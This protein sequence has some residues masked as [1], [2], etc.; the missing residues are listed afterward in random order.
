MTFFCTLSI[1]ALGLT[2]G[3]WQGRPATGEMAWLTACIASIACAVCARP[4]PAECA[5]AQ[6]VLPVVL[7][8]V[9]GVFAGSQLFAADSMLR[10]H[11][12]VWLLLGC[13]VL[14]YTVRRGIPSLRQCRTRIV[15]IVMLGFLL[16]SI[17]TIRDD[18]KPRIDVFLMQQASAKAM[19]E[20]RNPYTVSIPD[21][22]GPGSPYY[23]PLTRNGRTLYGFNY[24]PAMGFLDVPAY[25]LT[26]DI[27][28]GEVAALLLSSG[29]I[30]L[31][32][33]SWTALCGA[34]LLLINPYSLTMIHYAWT[35]PMLIFL[36][37]LTLF[38]VSRFPK[39]SPYIFGLF[40]CAKQTDL[41]ILPLGW[42]LVDGSRE[43]K[44]VAG[45]L[46]KSLG[47][48]IAIALPFYLWN[49]DAFILSTVT[50]QLRVPLR[51]DEISYSSYAATKGWFALPVWLP[52][53]YLPIGAYLV[54]WKAPRSTAG[55]AA[56]SA[57]ILVTFFALSK[58]G[59]TNYYF[60]EFG[61]MCCV[62]ALAN[63]NV[64][65]SAGS[66]ARRTAA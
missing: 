36:F 60:L 56:A 13:I 30:V 26:G 35:E 21:I 38:C 44:A 6:R 31:M 47:V 7:A 51:L 45:F 34:V 46:G 39:A 22:Y 61:M 11:I 63:G 57:L 65:E 42:M 18:P 37:C 8:C 49:P 41:A 29:L 48:A 43:W 23:I 15:P 40:L 14:L 5:R 62:L 16:L 28:Y 9:I 19:V 52:F 2:M 54:A 53:L 66:V 4:G 58:Q 59:G 55:F 64:D 27:R 25:V 24:P 3:M 12:S 20:L 50:L 32:Q 1:L 33:A 10:Y 17:K